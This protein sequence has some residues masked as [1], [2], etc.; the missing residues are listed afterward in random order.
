MLI[1]LWPIVRHTKLIVEKVQFM[2]AIVID[3]SINL[4]THFIDVIQKA[5]TKKKISLPFERLITRITIIA[6]VPLF[7][8][9]STIKMYGKISIVIVVKSEVMVSKKR[10]YPEESTSSK[11]ETP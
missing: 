7:D 10:S 5:T 2:Y 8:S 11:H 6:K 4:V 9:E 3:V 1:N